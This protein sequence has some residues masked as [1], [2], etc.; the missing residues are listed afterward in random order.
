MPAIAAAIAALSSD[1]VAQ[2]LQTG[3]LSVGGETVTAADLM[4]NRA[5]RAGLVVAADDQVA[6]AL[7]TEITPDLALEGTAREIVKL[8]Q[9]ARRDAGL[10]L[11][12]RVVVRWS[13]PSSQVTEAMARHGAWIAG[14]VLATALEPGATGR[15][16][17]AAG[18]PVT[19]EV[20]RAT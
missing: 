9:A 8:V 15:P 6:V 20:V 18:E 1:Q 2:A 19:L 11:S 7:D 17:D 3:S 5:P 4:V 14:E 13:S 10:D 12:D 16:S